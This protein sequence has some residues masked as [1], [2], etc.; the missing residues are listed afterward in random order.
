MKKL[1][2]LMAVVAMALVIAGTPKVAQAGPATN[3]FCGQTITQD[4]TL[5]GDLTCA[6]NGLTISASNVTLD[7]GGFTISGDPST[8]TG[9]LVV[10]S[11]GPP[12]RNV[13]I[14]NGTIKGFSR[15]VNVVQVH[16]TKLAHLFFTGQTPDSA[17]HAQSFF[18]RGVVIEDSA[19]F[20]SS[21]AT[22]S[23]SPLAILV[24]GGDNVLVQ[25]VDV[26]GY[27]QAVNFV[28]NPTPNS[29]LTN[30]TFA[31]NVVAVFVANTNALKISGNH[32]SGCIDHPTRTCTGIVICGSLEFCFGAEGVGVSDI[33]TENN[34]IHNSEQGI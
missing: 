10:P 29:K 3:A 19:F 4:T 31:D 15:G 28:A 1:T 12:V 13:T 27:Q 33:T 22:L 25:N 2:T 34:H 21:D 30:S 24:R 14:K 23:N 8:G 7:L 16:D 9:V 32:V 20:N 18:S 6:G 26:H 5:D 11:G 17:F